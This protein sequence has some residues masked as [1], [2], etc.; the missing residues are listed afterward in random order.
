MSIYARIDADQQVISILCAS[1]DD[2][3]KYELGDGESLVPVTPSEAVAFRDNPKA[4]FIDGIFT[5]LPIAVRPSPSLEDLRASRILELDAYT[6]SFIHRRDKS[7]RYSNSKQA[8]FN[9]IYNKCERRLR[10]AAL[11]D[12]IRDAIK[13]IRTVTPAR[14]YEWAM[15][16]LL[17]NDAP[18]ARIDE[19]NSLKAQY[20]AGT[21]TMAQLL[22]WANGVLDEIK[23]GYESKQATI[24]SV[25]KW[26]ESV[27]ARHYVHLNALKEAETLE[28]LDAVT[29]D[30][31]DL[32]A[33][34]PDVWLEHVI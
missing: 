34:D 10:R 3:I 15:D 14:A 16:I 32:N 18:H 5:V 2:L 12:D 11:P 26:I 13:S 6:S 9:A 24:D 8:S 21:V 17:Q 1:P 19:L 30:Y 22:S 29:W 20:Q 27:L 31:S 23:T 28:E 4:C 33:T 7:T 25:T